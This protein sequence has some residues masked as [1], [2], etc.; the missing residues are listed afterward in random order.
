MKAIIVYLIPTP[1]IGYVPR[2]NS[3]SPEK[4]RSR[5]TM[6]RWQRRRSSLSP[7]GRVGRAKPSPPKTGSLMELGKCITWMDFAYLQENGFFLWE[8]PPPGR[9][10][11]LFCK[12]T[13]E[14][15]VKD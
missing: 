10:K 5:S 1:S 11:G 12:I 13:V 15:E 8:E 9:R 2:T 4:S 3:A 14:L 6:I 7:R